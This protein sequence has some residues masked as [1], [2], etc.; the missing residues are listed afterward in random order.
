M[1]FIR[2]DRKVPV[3]RPS[4]KNIYND[5]IMIAGTRDWQLKYSPCKRVESAFSCPGLRC[6]GFWQHNSSFRPMTAAA[7]PVHCFQ[8]Q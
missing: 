7:S 1:T 3:S 4:P 5:Q 8:C 2:L 6:R